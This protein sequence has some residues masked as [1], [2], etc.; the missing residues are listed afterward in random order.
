MA[1]TS[2]PTPKIKHKSFSY[3][4]SLNW[5]GNRAGM[6]HS[7]GK[8]DFRVSSP[9]E[10][11]GEEGV[12]TPEDLFVAAV[13]VCTMTTFLAFAKHKKLAVHSY[14]TQAEGRLE[15]VDGKYQFTKVVLRP[16]I[17]LES[18]DETEQAR[19]ILEDAH[20]SCIVSNSIRTEVAIDP[21]IKS[22]D[23]HQKA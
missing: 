4:T 7:E 11:K 1:T 19:K 21:V 8:P 3:H 15:F 2:T 16:T 17:V 22:A 13:D 6:L 14:E 5:V 12:W 18:A 23:A 10:F 9:P 20:R